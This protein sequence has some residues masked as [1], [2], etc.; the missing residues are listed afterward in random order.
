MRELC[1]AMILRGNEPATP[2]AAPVARRKAGRLRSQPEASEVQA[3]PQPAVPPVPAPID[4]AVAQAVHTVPPS[5]EGGGRRTDCR[6]ASRA[7]NRDS[8]AAHASR[9]DA[10]QSGIAHELAAGQ[11][12]AHLQS[13][14]ET[15]QQELAR[16]PRDSAEAAR[17]NACLRLLCVIANRRDQAV[18]PIEGLGED[19]R[20]FWK[21]QLF[22]LLVSLDAD[23]QHTTSR[24]AALALRIC[25]QPR[26]VW[27]T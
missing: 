24:R 22:G 18:S 6:R 1:V 4:T 11:W 21:H 27:P 20:E 16:V 12:E 25:V 26:H 15:L 14:L 8:G 23:G 5:S 19:E 17:L 7:G 2:P 9:R 13:A 10:R 3:S